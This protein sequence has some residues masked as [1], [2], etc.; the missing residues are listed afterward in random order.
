MSSGKNVLQIVCRPDCAVHPNIVGLIESGM[1]IPECLRLKIGLVFGQGDCNRPPCAGCQVHCSDYTTDTAVGILLRKIVHRRRTGRGMA[2]NAEVELD[3]TGSPRT[4]QCDLTK[5]D[6]VVGVNKFPIGR[7]LRCPPYL[8]PDLGKD[9]QLY[10]WIFHSHYGP[11]FIHGSRSEPVQ[12]TVR[13]KP[14]ASSPGSGSCQDCYRI[15]ITERI[16][17]DRLGF[18]LYPRLSVNKG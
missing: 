15:G 11:F 8:T 3:S 9:R 4:S 10:I 14:R 18:L 12:K 17:P 5:L 2:D 13:V 16:G 1:I 7:L 6:N